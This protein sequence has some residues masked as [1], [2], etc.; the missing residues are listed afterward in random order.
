MTLKRPY[1]E[2]EQFKLSEGRRLWRR[3]RTKPP[4]FWWETFGILPEEVDLLR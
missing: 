4:S 3:H 1:D 2:M